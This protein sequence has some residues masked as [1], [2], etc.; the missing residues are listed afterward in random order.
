MTISE[1][2]GRD[3]CHIREYTLGEHGDWLPSKK[4]VAIRVDDAPSLLAL[5]DKLAKHLGITAQG[6]D[7][8]DSSLPF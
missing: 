8:D 4:G 3:Y 6:G 7:V 2:K 5:M 1:F